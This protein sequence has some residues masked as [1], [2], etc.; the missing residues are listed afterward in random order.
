MRKAFLILMLLLTICVLNGCQETNKSK[1]IN[2]VENTE[3]T[4]Y[5]FFTNTEGL[6]REEESNISTSIEGIYVESFGMRNNVN[7]SKETIDDIETSKTCKEPR[8][9]DLSL[10]KVGDVFI[11]EFDKD[12]KLFGEIY[13]DA[14]GK[15][16]LYCF[17]NPN[18][19]V[20]ELN[21]GMS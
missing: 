12:E 8:I 19:A 13:S 5:R 15:Y 17:D 10:S 21:Q 11:K 7:I 20:V 9:S 4:S 14:L 2:T 3:N 6:S 16:Y 1:N 18:N